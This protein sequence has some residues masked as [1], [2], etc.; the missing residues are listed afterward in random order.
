MPAADPRIRA[1]CFDAATV[2]VNLQCLHRLCIARCVVV[3]GSIKNQLKCVVSLYPHPS[4]TLVGISPSLQSSHVCNRM[5]KA[6]SFN[7]R[8]TRGENQRAEPSS[9]RRTALLTS[10]SI[11]SGAAA[12]NA[13]HDFANA[14]DT[15]IASS[16][17]GRET[18]ISAFAVPLDVAAARGSVTPGTISAFKQLQGKRARVK[19]QTVRSQ[20]QVL[21][22]GDA[23]A[24][25]LPDWLIAPAVHQKLIQPI[26]GSVS[27]FAYE[28]MADG[29][30]SLSKQL[31]D[32]VAVPYRWS[33]LGI[34]IRANARCTRGIFRSCGTAP[35][36]NAATFDWSDLLSPALFGRIALPCA[37]PELVAIA[38]RICGWSYDALPKRGND[39][40]EVV[41]ALEGLLRAA[42]VFGEA[43]GLRALSASDAVAAI[44]P[45]D[46]LQTLAERTPG[47]QATIPPSGTTLRSELWAAPA[48]K[49]RLSPLLA[50]WLAVSATGTRQPSMKHGGA[51]SSAS[52]STPSAKLQ[53]TSSSGTES[54]KQKQQE[55]SKHEKKQTNLINAH[56]AQCI[57]AF[58][59]DAAIASLV[60]SIASDAARRAG[61]PSTPNVAL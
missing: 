48:K 5:A 18:S 37:W 36:N 15:E 35:P 45:V 6:Q 9:S 55:E 50:Q 11:I 49:K 56:G 34:G 57:S 17:I 47:M 38:L 42:L 10:A 7:A 16:S 22:K 4:A 2:R 20:L 1:C 51:P 8:T 3:V 13:T 53:L 44:A 59:G 61:Y 60:A 41:Q 12:S 21:Q 33:V 54:V 46:G 31:C 29:W 26:P 25:A 19:V 24:V 27:S 40:E 14:A 39:Q 30:Y 28:Q 23:D 58:I 32:A 52:L 43:E